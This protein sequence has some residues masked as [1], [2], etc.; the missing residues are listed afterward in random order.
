MKILDSERNSLASANYKMSKS[1]GKIQTSGKMENA[2][3]I[4]SSF[5]LNA[6]TFLFKK[7]YTN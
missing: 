5:A 4:D 7:N 6:Q 2:D 3:T 1:L